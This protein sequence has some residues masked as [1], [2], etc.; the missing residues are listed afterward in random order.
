[1][2]QTRPEKAATSTLLLKGWIQAA[3][4]VRIYA[5]HDDLGR[6]FDGSCVSG[7]MTRRRTLPDNLQNQ[8][9][10]IYGSWIS[11]NELAKMAA[12]L[13]S[14]G[15]ENYCSSPRIALIERVV[16]LKSPGAD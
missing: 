16:L 5:R 8:Y 7:A 14:I 9:V 2:A 12:N 13:E 3:G 4:E 15:V 11:A 1:M 6:L 10:A